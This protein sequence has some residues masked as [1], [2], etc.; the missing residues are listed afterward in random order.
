ET[1]KGV[2]GTSIDLEDI[3]LLFYLSNEADRNVRSNIIASDFSTT[4]EP[5]GLNLISVDKAETE[6]GY[7]FTVKGEGDDLGRLHIL[8]HTGLEASY[9]A[10][11]GTTGKIEYLVLNASANELEVYGDE[12]SKTKVTGFG[13]TASYVE[14]TQ[15]WTVTVNGETL[16]G[17]LGTSI[18]LEDIGLL[19]YLSNEADRNVRSNIIASDF[20]TTAAPVG[21]N[22]ISV[23]KKEADGTEATEKRLVF[24]IAINF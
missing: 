2:L 6:E 18:D 7:T 5:V 24:R 23:D 16:K 9:D 8:L 19:F 21:L 10:I 22:L 1:L 12:A 15:T 3:G 4:E 11:D 17:V 20:S 13:V 14:A